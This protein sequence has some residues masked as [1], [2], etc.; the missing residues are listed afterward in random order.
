MAILRFKALELVDQR[1]VVAPEVDTRKISDFFGQNVFGPGAM[2]ATMSAE[3]PGANG[4]IS[5]SGLLG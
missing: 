5:L 3:P 1:T 2:R 4:T